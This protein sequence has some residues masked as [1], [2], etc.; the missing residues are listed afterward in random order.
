MNFYVDS[1]RLE[2]DAEAIQYIKKLKEE[3]TQI[4]KYIDDFC[5]VVKNNS[6]ANI[7]LNL[8]YYPTH[9]TIKE[10]KYFN[11][12]I[13]IP[14]FT[15]EISGTTSATNGMVPYSWVIKDGFC[16]GNSI[17]L[18]EGET[19]SG[20][21]VNNFSYTNCEIYTDS[22]P[23]IHQRLKSEHFIE[24]EIKTIQKKFDKEID[25]LEQKYHEDFR[26]LNLQKKNNNKELQ[27]LNALEQNLKK[28]INKCKTE[29]KNKE[30]ICVQESKEELFFSIKYD[31]N[32]L[33]N[34]SKLQ[35]LKI[36][37]K[38]KELNKP[39][40]IFDLSKFSSEARQLELDYPE[41][42]L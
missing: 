31:D 15:G 41:Y 38:P 1:N 6:K 24:T 9:F 5:S 32:P 22:L 35:N 33:L 7:T 34:T 40:K 21:G 27:E 3:A 17:F 25:A 36:L 37:I 30:M 8:D 12:G 39:S 13:L 28:M 42:L 11:N 14:M 29:I 4:D 20:G 26:D 16:T 2:G 10:K 23:K 18:F 19:G